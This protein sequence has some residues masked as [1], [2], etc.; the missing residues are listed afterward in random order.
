M[1]RRLV[2]CA[3]LLLAAAAPAAAQFSLVQTPPTRVILLVDSSG[4]TQ[5]HFQRFRTALVD[6]L[7]AL[8]PN[9]EVGLI[10][11]GGQMRVRQAPTDELAKVRRAA[12][13]FA[14]D[15]GA[16]AFLDAL[17]E[18]DQRFMK[19]AGDKRQIFIVISTDSEARTEP[20]VDDYNRFLNDF[21]QRGG[22]AHAF[23]FRDRQ[24]GLV[25]N[26]LDNLTRNTR[27]TMQVMSLSTTL[28][29]A[30][31]ELALKIAEGK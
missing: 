2:G 31:Q 12:E 18:A 1:M 15:G 9:V 30:M 26:V 6:F 28:P 3:L 8:P 23:V 25:S 7:D 27:G 29:A 14:P 13:S 22:I 16:N 20:R 19:P 10:S 4:A 17:V 5:T 21:L 11:T 24:M